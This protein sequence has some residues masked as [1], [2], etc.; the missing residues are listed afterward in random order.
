MEFNCPRCDNLWPC[1]PAGPGRHRAAVSPRVQLKRRGVPLPLRGGIDQGGKR[2]QRRQADL[3]PR[4]GVHSRHLARAERG[5]G[6]ERAAGAQPSP[7]RGGSLREDAQR[8][9]QKASCAESA[10]PTAVYGAVARRFSL[11]LR[12]TL[13]LTLSALARRCS[14]LLP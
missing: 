6:G 11:L 5:K 10:L 9:H 14:F 12:T 8:R 7:E 13:T 1:R 4:R 3:P 2:A